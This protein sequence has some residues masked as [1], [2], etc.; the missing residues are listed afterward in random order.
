MLL[1]AP[2]F[3]AWIQ[4]SSVTL[5]RGA[6]IPGQKFG[7]FDARDTVIDPQNPDASYG[8]DPFL[9]S[10]Q[11]R[12][13]LIRFGDL[14]RFVA[15]RK[16]KDAKITFTTTATKV[17]VK[18]VLQIMS[19]W[20]EGPKPILPRSFA[21]IQSTEIPAWPVSGADWNHG[22]GKKN[23]NR[24]GCAGM[25]DAIPATGLSATQNGNSVEIRGLAELCQRWAAEPASNNG[26][27]IETE[28]IAEFASCDASEAQPRLELSLGE[29]LGRGL[30]IGAIHTA[31]ASI[32]LTI[33]NRGTTAAS[34][35]TEI[36]VRTNGESGNSIPL[37][38]TIGPGESKEIVL[39][40]RMPAQP[41]SRLATVTV[42]IQGPLADPQF[43]SVSMGTYSKPI[44]VTLPKSFADSLRA[45][46]VDPGAWVLAQIE[47]FNSTVIPFSRF[48][49]APDGINQSFSI[50]EVNEGQTGSVSG[51]Q[52]LAAFFKWQWGETVQPSGISGSYA[53]GFEGF[54][55]TRFEGGLVKEVNPLYQGYSS[56]LATLLGKPTGLLS[57]CS[58]YELEKGEAAKF[59]TVYYL[60]IMHADGSPISRAATT[61][62]AIGP[63]GE[64]GISTTTETNSAG[65]VNIPAQVRG[66]SS[67]VSVKV[68]TG[69]K[70]AT[71]VIPSWQFKDAYA[72]G[73]K[74]AFVQEI[75][76]NLPFTTISDKVL[77]AGKFVTDSS[78]TPSSELIGL[79]GEAPFD[80]I[81]IKD[82][83]EI[84]LGRDRPLG[85][86]TIEGGMPERFEIVAYGTGQTVNEAFSWAR[87][88]HFGWAKADHANPNGS[89]SYFGRPIV[90]RFV[91]IVN[92]NSPHDSPVKRVKVYAAEIN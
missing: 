61:L 17:K 20:R 91:R 41:K 30:Q 25:L 57:L 55:D 15:A 68:T 59:P 81:R 50:D 90:A 92:K 87:E 38:N 77:S 64:P 89:I 75:R 51:P 2:I 78:N 76:L 31:G 3:N 1:L 37:G 33:H 48:S 7:Y 27:L 36:L 63:S 65:A 86:I 18:R 80:G 70:S 13:V 43:A 8:T 39:D 32:K 56:P 82:W 16:I 45:N 85:E 14:T 42:T 73:N 47:F 4:E 62:Q 52:P 23:W 35:S 49:F 69:G 29:N 88:S 22:Y 58:A 28:D 84:D 9:V 44:S 54:G 24:P 71:A 67:G 12:L 66:D 26:L 83:I 79:T 11:G 46:N 72:R 6:E 60:N 40:Y 10:G 19:P 34:P 74:N 5:F 21:T 53:P